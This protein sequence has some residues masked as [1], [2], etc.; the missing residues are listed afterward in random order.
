MVMR[1]VLSAKTLD[2][3]GDAIFH[4]T[5]NEKAARERLSH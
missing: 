5:R 1:I 3:E 2:V 4:H